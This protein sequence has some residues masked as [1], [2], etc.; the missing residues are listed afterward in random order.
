MTFRRLPVL[1][2]VVLLAAPASFAQSVDDF[3]VPLTPDTKPSSSKTKKTKTKTRTKTT[4]KKKRAVKRPVKKKATKRAT[5][6]RGSKRP[7]VVEQTPAL[8]EELTIAPLVAAK[9]ELRVNVP[10][11]IQGA[12]LFID[13]QEV[14][15]LP[16]PV[17]EIAP[18]A[19]TIVVRRPGFTEFNQRVHIEEGRLNEVEASLEAV[20]GVVAVTVD[21]PG[22]AVFIDGQPHGTAPLSGVLLAPGS[23]VLEARRDGF[24]PDQKSI[25]VRAGRDYT[26]GFHLRPAVGDGRT[27]VASADRP[28]APVLTPKASLRPDDAAVALGTDTRDE[29]K[30]TPLTSRWYFWAGVGAV[31]AAGVVGTVVM[32]QDGPGKPLTLDDVCGP[33]GCDGSINAPTAASGAVRF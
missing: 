11:T 19:H 20:A 1:A 2:V 23:H 26:V 15:T 8:D 10:G 4:P 27:P 32:T 5:V 7:A 25:I 13:G 33:G 17:Q 22:A 21:V 3:L 30:S 6:K 28:T 9:T 18:G 24:E 16:V 12:R 14:G 29:V 31:V